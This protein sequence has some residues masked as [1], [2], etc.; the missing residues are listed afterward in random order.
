MNK[1]LKSHFLNLYSMVIADGEVSNKEKTELYRLGKLYGV[2]EKELSDLVFADD[3]VSYIPQEDEDKILYLYD[4]ALIAWADGKVTDD[5][6]YLLNVYAERFGVKKEEKEK[7]ISYLL[8][9]A[10]KKLSHEAI[11]KEFSE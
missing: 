6:K 9:E 3:I 11:L 4:L 10:Q 5:E 1:E 7:L 8:N 2:T